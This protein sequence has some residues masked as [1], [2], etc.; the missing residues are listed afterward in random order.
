ME[1]SLEPGKY[2][3]AVSG[4]V[5]SMVLLNLLLSVPGVDFVVAHFDHGIRSDSAD[6]AAFVRHAAER[7]GLSFFSE[8]GKLGSA[9]SEEQAR[10]ARYNFLVRV[11]NQTDASAIITAHHQDDVLETAILNLIR[12]TGR[13]GLASLQSTEE[14][15]RPLLHI[16]KQD[17]IVYAK[18]H[19]IAWREDSTNQD[20]KYARNYVRHAILP[21]FDAHAR[22]KLLDLIGKTQ[23][24]NHRIDALIDETITLTAA[25]ISRPVIIVSPYDISCEL[26]ASWLRAHQLEFDRKTIHR[27]VVQC[28]TLPAGKYVDVSGKWCI[29]MRKDMLALREKI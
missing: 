22:Q 4:G 23:T 3:V 11:Q 18:S 15:V 12:G 24:V 1:V 2:V 14:R 20:T 13:K 28:K 27:I 10:T 5:D 19:A 17:I 8:R 7:L 29:S 16:S 6:D 26:I 9:A 21:R 25:A